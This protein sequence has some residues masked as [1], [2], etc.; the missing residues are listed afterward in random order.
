MKMLILGLLLAIALLVYAAPTLGEG[1]T[2]VERAAD[3]YGH[4]IH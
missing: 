1:R 3:H 4:Q 2:N